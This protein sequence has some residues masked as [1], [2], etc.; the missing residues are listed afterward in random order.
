MD[1]RGL[2]ARLTG[3]GCTSCGAAIPVERIVVLA[4]RGDFA[5]VELDCQRCGS[6]TMGLVLA[7]PADACPV[8][9]TAGH[10]EL[11]PQTAARVASRPPVGEDDLFA[12]HRLLE[13]WTGDLRTLLGDD[14]RHDGGAAR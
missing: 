2:R 9:D 10:P 1:P 13:G 5:F 12:M 11:D 4:D 7:A 8:L 3:A 6:R 14:S